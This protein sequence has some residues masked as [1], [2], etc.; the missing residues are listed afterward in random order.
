MH[1]ALP[2][3][4]RNAPHKMPHKMLHKMPHKVR[5][6]ARHNARHVP[7]RRGGTEGASMLDG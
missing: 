3:I 4:G 6:N 2:G 1:P 7:D 5:H